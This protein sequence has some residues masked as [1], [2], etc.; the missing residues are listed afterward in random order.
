ME[1]KKTSVWRGVLRVAAFALLFTFLLHNVSAVLADKRFRD[2]MAALYAEPRNSVE[3]LL[4]GS[5]R[6]HNGI[7]AARLEEEFG[8]RS[9]NFSQDGQVLP[10]TW[11][12]LKEA[13][14]YQR[15]RV[16]VLDVYKVIQDSLIDSPE[17]LH[18]TADNMRPGLPKAQMVF[19]LLPKGER[20]EFLFNIITYHTR[21]KELTAADFAP[22]DV[23]AKGDEILT[24]TY[25]P[26]EGFS[27]V[28]EEVTAPGAECELEY[29]DKIVDLCQREGIELLLVSVP[30]TTAE[31]DDLHRQEVLNGMAAYAEEKGLPYLNMMHM[32]EELGFDFSADM[33]DMY[34]LNEQ[35]MI[36]VTDYLG[37]YLRE[38]YGFK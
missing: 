2:S 15:P 11:Y 13:L 28:P 37:R 23:S 1:N 12:A 31:N 30:F 6:V 29:L 5:S 4:L 24:G 38:N 22:A 14:R 35:G 25:E 18:R 32:T 20:A 36:K 3:V 19:D 17:S 8:I 21:W 9:N 33:A 7:S 26:Y 34:H 10:V 16:V 27:V